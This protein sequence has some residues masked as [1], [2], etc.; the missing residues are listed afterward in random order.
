MYNYSFI[1]LI[2]VELFQYS[3]LKYT[4]SF[5]LILSIVISIKTFCQH[6]LKVLLIT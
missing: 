6:R 2:N 1:H 4:N 5:L 3:I